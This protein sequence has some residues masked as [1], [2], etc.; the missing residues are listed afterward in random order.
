VTQGSIANPEFL[1]IFNRICEVGGPWKISVTRAGIDLDYDGEHYSLSDS[2]A[3]V[4]WDVLPRKIN[5]S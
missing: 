2:Q 5:Q 1:K 3:E 4:M